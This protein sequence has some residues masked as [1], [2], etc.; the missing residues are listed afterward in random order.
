MFTQFKRLIIGK[1][2][3]NRDLKN[4]KI[5]NFKALAILS[6]DALSSVAYGPE[7]ILIT[8][9]MVGAIASWY[10]LPIAAAV[11]VLLAALILSYRQI[12][13]AYPKG[14]GAYMVSKTNL[15]EKW[16]L[17]A[18]GSLL[19]DYILTVA[20]SISSGA[21]AFVAAF[22]ALYHYKVFI[23]CLLVLFILIMNL[24]GLTESATVL[25]YPV[26]LF[27]IGLIVMIIIGTW[28]VA[29]G[30]AEPHMQATVGTAVPGVT[31]FLLLKAF[32]SGASSLTGVEAIS[33][34][35]TN[36]KDPGSKNAVK[37]LIT[38][39]MILAFL[40]VGI[41]GLAYWYGIMPQTETTVLSQLAMNI[42]GHNV[43]YYFVQ[44]TT[45]MILV[46]AANT[47]FTAFPM[48]AASMSKDKYMPRMFNV[49]GDRL[50]Y[51]NSIIT[52]GICAMLLIIF[53]HGKTEN[54]IPLY[55]VGVFIPFT[56]AQYGMVLKWIR[57]REKGW[58][59]KLIANAIGGTITFIVFMIFLITKFNQVWPILIFLP[60][61]VYIFTRINR[62]YKDIAEQLSTT[63]I[64]QDMPV[65]D[66]NLAIVPVN[67]ITTALNK[68]IYYAHMIADDVIAIHV[69]FG[70]QTDNL[71]IEKWNK[72]YPDI[73]LVTLHS[74][75]RSV[76][77][78]I[79]RFIDKINKKANDQNYV[80][81]VVVT[82][83]IPK[84]PWHNFL[85]NQTSLRL[86]MHL[87]YQKNVILATVPYKLQ[88]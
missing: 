30:Q 70:D 24:R 73:R 84:K 65:V 18:G 2:K 55:A 51:S 58:S 33:N 20:V 41:V 37:T 16:G 87:F 44:V 50:G 80:I 35:V 1:P 32:S 34:A 6:S 88:K 15:G 11:L 29:T 53:F 4:E 82:E 75:Y 57:G 12:I 83:F 60:I 74:E 10:T 69:S 21:D 46:L 52:L 77:R 26:Y 63:K 23:A 85:H 22:P 7:Q 71:F 14:G 36:F 67:T 62:H 42:L 5:S 56:L 78:P 64:V 27:I 66:K 76:I 9:S 17:L 3:K 45:V 59:T 47:G 39:G 19:V 86:K 48:L 25:S 8:L 79:S 61:V 49:R 28:Q 68:S 72:Q 40:L 38:M 31:L 43:G 54:L 81:T 13:Y